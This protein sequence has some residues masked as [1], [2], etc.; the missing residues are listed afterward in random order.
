MNSDAIRGELVPSGPPTNAHR[1]RAAF[2]ARYS[3]PHTFKA[4]MAAV[5]RFYR[6]CDSVNVDPLAVERGHLEF[7][8]RHLEQLGLAKSSVAHHLNALAGLFKY[9]YLDGHIPADPMAHVRRPQ[10]PRESTT[11]GLTRTEFADIL[12]TAEATARDHALV[13]LLGLCGLR[14]SEVAGIDVEHLGFERGYTTVLITRKGGK[15]QLIPL[16]QQ[17]AWAV[18]RLRRENRI[19]TGPLFVRRDGNRMDRKTA[20][21]W[22]KRLAAAAGVRKRI[23]PHSFRH[24]FVTHDL[25]LRPQPGV[26]GAQRHAR[27]HRLRRRGGVI[28]S[29]RRYTPCPWRRRHR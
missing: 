4:Y 27:P 5:D 11:N 23:S 2:L 18:D 6:W 3:N 29:Q 8:G 19:E 9:A 28:T 21:R 25:V 15:T 10:V 14:V 12:K 22:V 7:Y 16:S 20:D 1:A 26:A 24:T 17:T 13:C